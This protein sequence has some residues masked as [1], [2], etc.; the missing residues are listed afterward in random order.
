MAKEKLNTDTAECEEQ[1]KANIE[2][3]QVLCK[4]EGIAEKMANAQILHTL[5]EL[6]PS[7]LVGFTLSLCIV[8]EFHTVMYRNKVLICELITKSK[9]D[10]Q[11]EFEDWMLK[12]TSLN[13]QIQKVGA[14]ISAQRDL[15][16][17]ALDSSDG[18]IEDCTLNA[19]NEVEL[20][21]DVAG[22]VVAILPTLLEAGLDAAFGCL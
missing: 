15:M 21:G 20:A 1:L 3:L 18:I 19:M 14:K 4:E 10:S 22:V 5:K 9:C 13:P 8:S 17:V 11:E 6:C 16:K 2:K 7:S 12:N